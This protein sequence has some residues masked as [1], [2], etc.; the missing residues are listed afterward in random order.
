MR[1]RRCLSGLAQADPG[2]RN[3]KRAAQLLGCCLQNL[4]NI[5]G[6]T[7]LTDNVPGQALAM[8]APL[9]LLKESLVFQRY[10]DLIGQGRH[11]RLVVIGPHAVLVIKIQHPYG[12]TQELDRHSQTTALTVVARRIDCRHASGFQRG[13]YLWRPDVRSGA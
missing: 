8:S 12:L 5:A 9:C 7:D 1:R 4:L 6:G 2:A 11:Q 10:G 13:L 3:P